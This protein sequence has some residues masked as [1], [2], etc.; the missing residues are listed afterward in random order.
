VENE[1]RARHN[2]RAEKLGPDELRQLFPG[3]ARDIQ[4]GLFIPDNGHTV[5]PGRAVKTL[6]EVFLAEGGTILPE[7]ALKLIPRPPGWFVLSNTGNHL[8]DAVVVAG[9]AW[10]GALLA[11]LGVRV[12]LETERGYHAHLP[13]PSIELRLPILQKTRGF[14]LTPMEDGLR[15]AGTVEIAGLDAPPDERRAALLAEQA[16]RLFPDL[17]HGTPKLWM[18]YRPSLPDSLPAVGPAPGQPGLFLCFGHGHF[19]MTGGPPSGRLV[20]AL[21][22]G[23]PPPVDPR[24]YAPGRF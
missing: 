3:I 9:G 10:S 6:A 20:A 24:A 5:S 12:P 7:R 4:R 1:L 22:A 23:L 16:K 21:V 11:P 19:G 14:G 15:A 18:G 13:G 2:V 17:Q 8:A